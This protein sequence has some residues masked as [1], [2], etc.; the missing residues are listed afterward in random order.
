[1][2]AKRKNNKEMYNRLQSLD[3]LRGSMAL[4][5]MLYHFKG[6]GDASSLLGKLGIYGV[7]IFFILSGLS[8]AIAYDKYNMDIRNAAKFF[9]RRLFRIWPLLWLAVALVAIPNYFSGTSMGGT[10]ILLNLSTLFGFVAPTQYIN[11]GA[12]S[13][14][15]EMVYYA[16][17]PICIAAYQWRRWVGNSITLA[18]IGIGFGFAFWLLSP[19]TT[20]GSQWDVYI[21]PFNNLF[22]YCVGLGIYYNFRIEIARQ[23][24]VPLFL[25]AVGLFIFYPASGN[26][27]NLVTGINRVAM[28]LI[29]IM[30]VLV[31]YKCPPV[32]SSFISAK[33]EQLGVA[34]YGVYLLHPIVMDFTKSAFQALG[35]Q[36]KLVPALIAIVLTIVLS[37]CTFKF[38]EHPMIRL[39]KRVTS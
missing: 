29:S 23:W 9:V 25:L 12:W 39:G 30:I 34:T 11:T 3:W 13:I 27:I 10:I 15:N 17:T 38:V 1:M 4:A 18:A 31:M 20:L 14:G 6:G 32:L 5:I 22:L 16:L 37:L 2:R 26:Q 24:H 8:M 28:S 35:I 7:S 19:T 33:F 36:I 21:N